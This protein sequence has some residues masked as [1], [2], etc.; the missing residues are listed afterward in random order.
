[1]TVWKITGRFP[2]HCGTPAH[3]A[4]NLV[5]TESI[6]QAIAAYRNHYAHA[7]IVK[8]EQLGKLLEDKSWQT[9]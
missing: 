4:E 7:E 3:N 9:A 1:M 5:L 6:S 2:S 8:I